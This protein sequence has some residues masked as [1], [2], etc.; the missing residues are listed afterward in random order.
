MSARTDRALES[1]PATAAGAA[2][3]HWRD[4]PLATEDQRA[5]ARAV[6]AS[7]A[8]RLERGA[9]AFDLDWKAGPAANWAGLTVMASD[10]GQCALL[11]RQERPLPLHLGEKTW[12][13]MPLV[14]HT[15]VGSLLIG[16]STG[17]GA[18]AAGLLA[19]LAERLPRRDAIYCE[20]IALDD[21]VLR[22]LE[23]AP[24]CLAHYLP[25][26]LGA[27]FEH[28]VAELPDRFDAYLATLSTRSRQSVLYS[29]RKLDQGARVELRCYTSSEQVDE[30]LRHG[31]AVSRLTY[32]W[33]L[34]GLGLR[35]DAETRA[36]L[37]LAAEHGWL[38]SYLLWAD[39]KAVAFMLGFQYGS[40]YDYTDV[41]FDPDRAAASVGTVLQIKVMRHLYASAELPR[42]TLFDFSTGYGAHKARF[43][44][45]AREEVN[46]LL[47]PRSLRG[48]VLRAAYTGNEA[49]VAALTRTLDRWGLKA[50][51]KKLMRARAGGE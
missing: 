8:C 37:M 4:L 50:R 47:L 18:D 14:R 3:S 17:A 12:L 30:F 19:A 2:V 46:L 10:A 6:L 11:L 29:E 41:G 45:R 23:T 5:A 38:R 9:M 22:Q 27:P 25:L 21:P 49:A 31:S 42:P 44:N 35:D 7:A 13:A 15:T 40:G 48:R 51:I 34:L 1:A 43:G 36:T 20:G 26:R 24:R 33:R 39:G 32:Q 16:A 28:H